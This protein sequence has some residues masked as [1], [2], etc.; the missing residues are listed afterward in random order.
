MDHMTSQSGDSQ[1]ALLARQGE[2]ASI[3]GSLEAARA[4][5]G[6]VTLLLGGAGLGK[7]ELLARSVAL[8]CSEGMLVLTARGGELERELPFGVARQLFERAVSR[9]PAPERAAVMSGAASIVR[10]LLGLTGAEIGATDPHGTIHALYWLLANLSERAS[11][12]LAIDDLHWVDPQTVRW[13]SYLSGRITELPVLVIAA[14]RGSEPGTGQPLASL[15]QDDAVVRLTLKPLGVESVGE[16]I[17]SDLG[18]E[19]DAAFVEA[20]HNATAGNPFFVKELLRAALSQGIDPVESQATKVP[21]LGPHEVAQAILVRLGRLGAPERRLAE[22]VAV[23]GTDAELRHAAALSEISVERAL[24]IWDGLSRAEILQARQPLEF[25]HPIARTAVYREMAAGK[26]S[27]AHRLAAEILAADRAEWHRIATHAFAC[28]PAAD[29][30]VV[31]WL[32]I[33]A[34]GAVRAGAPD[35]AAAYLR[36]ALEEPPPP[37]VRAEVQFELGRALIGV[38]SA[39]AAAAFRQAALTSSDA[40]LRLRAFR[41]CGHALAFAGQI[42][43]A[44]VA[45]DH[46]IELAPDSETALH[47]AATRDFFAVWWNDVPNQAVYRKQLQERAL[48]LDGSTPGSKRASAVAALGICLTGSAPAARALELAEQA[49]AV[50]PMRPDLDEGDE[51]AAAVVAVGIVCDDPRRSILESTIKESATQG[52]ILLAARAH[53]SLAILD[54][55]RGALFSAEAHARASWEVLGTRRD[56]SAALHWWSAAVLVDVLVARGALEEASAMAQTTGLGDTSMDH[57]IFPW[58][59]V[60]RGA[61]ELAQGNID[62]GLQLVL[63][64]GI[65]LER[66]GI[67]N[68]SFIPWRAVAAP[69]L[70]AAGRVDEARELILPAVQRATEFGSPWALGMALRVAGT[71]EQGAHGIELLHKAIGV[72]ERSPC[73][74]EHAHALLELGAALRRRRQRLEARSYLRAALDLTH[75]CGAVGLAAQ[76]EQQLAAAGARPRRATLSGLESLTASERRVAELAGAGLSN[77]EIAQQLFV[78]RK[79]IETHLGHVYLKLAIKSR[80]Q[81]SDRLHSDGDAFTPLAMSSPRDRS[82]KERE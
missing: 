30:A 68:P 45:F 82:V 57:V 26:R 16:M 8:A 74:L 10:P 34:Q 78:T 71:V 63:D 79:T 47:L 13:L 75:R 21:Q 58:P 64:A 66:N 52:W 40:N 20:C 39:M 35:A 41:W 61:L 19:A 67:A 7:T 5:R 62:R 59:P 27:R 18:T 1:V 6:G 54:L 70:V 36:R 73:R 14:A 81:L 15:T 37:D 25:I 31:R 46:A 33:A 17:L 80:A 9:M 50:G 48:D 22:S 23:L 77:P 38:D 32:R 2:L 42:A 11:L 53:R 65:R 28:E 43:E 76:A 60:T 12:V 49:G 4:G 56:A 72:L 55:R 24:V 69:A 51:T 3:D 29:P 44:V